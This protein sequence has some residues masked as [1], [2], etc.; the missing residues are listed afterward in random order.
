MNGLS[1]EAHELDSIKLEG[2]KQDDFKVP[3]ANS[4]ESLIWQFESSTDI[5]TAS[6]LL[7]HVLNRS[8]LITRRQGRR[9]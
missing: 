2:I 5:W 4:R 1:K 8:Y 9:F 7:C 3:G 6:Q